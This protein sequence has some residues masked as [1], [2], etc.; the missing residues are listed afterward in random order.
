MPTWGPAWPKLLE[1]ALNEL[2]RGRGA[3]VLVH[4]GVRLHRSV[5]GGVVHLRDRVPVVVVADVHRLRDRVVRRVPGVGVDVEAAERD[6]VLR[7]RRIERQDV[8]SIGAAL[9]TG[10]T[11]GPARSARSTPRRRRHRCSRRR[12]RCRSIRQPSPSR[13]RHRRGRPRFPRSFY[14]S[15]LRAPRASAPHQQSRRD[16]RDAP[17]RSVFCSCAYLAAGKLR[18]AKKTTEHAASENLRWYRPAHGAEVGSLASWLCR[19]IRAG[20]IDRMRALAARILGRRWGDGIARRRA[21]RRWRH[22]GRARWK[23]RGHQRNGRS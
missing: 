2:M 7:V 20:C 9:R 22:C 5:A 1:M 6:P 19:Y 21:L 18:A 4:V 8:G 23:R 10:L 11:A 3:E 15:S 12:L 16:A 13:R 14:K 17:A